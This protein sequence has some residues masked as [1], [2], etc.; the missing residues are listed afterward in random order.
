MNKNIMKYIYLLMIL[1]C[2][3]DTYAHKEPTHQYIIREAY[4]LLKLHLGRPIPEYENHILGADG[5]EGQFHGY[6]SGFGAWNYWTVPGGAWNEDQ[7]DVI[8][9]QDYEETFLGIPLDRPWTSLTHFW[10]C[11]VDGVGHN[12]NYKLAVEWNPF[13]A[14][15]APACWI[16]RA[17][18]TNHDGNL[19]AYKKAMYFHGYSYPENPVSSFTFDKNGIHESP[20][21]FG[22]NIIQLHNGDF[23]YGYI[24]NPTF[25]EFEKNS[26]VY[27]MIGRIC[28]LLGDMSVPAHVAATNEDRLM[29]EHGLWH[30]PYEDGMNYKEWTGNG[31]GPCA[32]GSV[33]PAYAARVEY[34]NAKKVFEEKG[35]VVNPYCYPEN[36]HPIYYLFYTTAQISDHFATNRIDG[37]NYFPAGTGN[38]G[39]IQNVINIDLNSSHPGPK[40]SE[41]VDGDPDA[42]GYSRTNADIDAIRD[43]TFPYVIRA[44]AGLLYYYAKEFGLLKETDGEPGDCEDKILLQN[45]NIQGQNYHF[46]ASDQI[47]VGSNVIP[48][49]TNGN[50]DIYSSAKNVVFRSG[51]EI[52]FKDGF[53]VRNGANVHAYIGPCTDCANNERYPYI[54]PLTDPILI[55]PYEERY[56]K[57]GNYQQPVPLTI[58]IGSIYSS[59]FTRDGDK[60]GHGHGSCTN[61]CCGKSGISR[62]TV[63]NPLGEKVYDIID[64]GA[65]LSEY[66]ADRAVQ[67]LTG[68]WLLS[69]E[70]ENGLIE[71]RNVFYVQR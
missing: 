35:S 12:A 9:N 18:L 11:D 60:E 31:P 69:L 55:K 5:I 17:G 25:T 51:N 37:D 19:M 52:V 62:L 6:T 66:M 41:F 22:Y 34:W 49:N 38:I 15:D 56:S 61:S 71:K 4:K 2:C 3:S 57:I 20:G 36:T 54:T 10:D 40:T 58:S 43:A 64:A 7:N 39:E 8:T 29:N 47:K 26:L 44:T 45:F 32:W 21:S 46:G 14:F 63:T 1:L 24:G 42:S 70:H 28:H 50:V 67:G 13:S 53:R 33:L 65:D 59:N 48:T 30:D 23:A 68:N 16:A 27:N